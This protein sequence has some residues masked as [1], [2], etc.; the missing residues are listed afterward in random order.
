MRKFS[1]YEIGVISS[2][3]GMGLLLISLTLSTGGYPSLSFIQNINHREIVV[4]EG[5]VVPEKRSFHTGP[6]GGR[7][8]YV[9][10][11]S[12]V[13]GRMAV[14]LKYPLSLSV[15]LVLSGLGLVLLGKKG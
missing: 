14:P 11:E 10:E 4:A 6:F 7:S 13:K 3:A 12:Y 5:E 2:L 15:L 8:S 9:S 1:W